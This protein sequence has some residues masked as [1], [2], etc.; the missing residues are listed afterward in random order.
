MSDGAVGK[1]ANYTADRPAV[2][3]FEASRGAFYNPGRH[4]FGAEAAGMRVMI[5]ALIGLTAGMSSG[6]FGIGG[7][8]LV[9]PALIYLLDFP[10]HRAIGTSLAVLLPPI[11]AAAVYAYY[12]A[13]HIDWQAA[14]I[15]AATLFAGAWL[16]AIAANHLNETWL[17]NLFGIFLIALGC[18][19]LFP[20][21]P[22]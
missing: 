22:A 16:G 8:V 6:L 21:K 11:G 12:R 7:G 4:R 15:L 13:G 18:Y 19:T 14:I 20:G 5:L 1:S 17:R 3:R 2:S 10:A 9:V